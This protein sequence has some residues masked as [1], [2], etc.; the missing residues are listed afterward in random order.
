[1]QEEKAVEP[2]V[3]DKAYASESTSIEG[4]SI[5]E[6][7]EVFEE[8]PELEGGSFESQISYYADAF[9]GGVERD[10]AEVIKEDGHPAEYYYYG[11]AQAFMNVYENA[12]DVRDGMKEDFN[13]LMALSY[14]IDEEQGKV[15]DGVTLPKGTEKWEVHK[16]WNEP[17]DRQKQAIQYMSLVFNDLDIAANQLS[18]EPAGYTYFS[19]GKKVEEIEE[20]ISQK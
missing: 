8:N 10:N 20:F 7:E 9:G 4:L 13:N 18:K 3:E 17:T 19:D 16:Y 12:T 5:D 14:I 11:E 2:K 15:L 1:M 6:V